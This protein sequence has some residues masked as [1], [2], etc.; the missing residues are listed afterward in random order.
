MGVTEIST[1]GSKLEYIIDALIYRI[2]EDDTND[3]QRLLE[4]ADGSLKQ[5]NDFLVGDYITFN[6]SDLKFDANNSYSLYLDTLS[7]GSKEQQ[8]FMFFA[9]KSENSKYAIALTSGETNSIKDIDDLANG[10]T[11]SV[12]I[13]NATG[14]SENLVVVERYVAS[15]ADP[16]C[17]RIT[18]TA[19]DVAD[20]AECKLVMK[21]PQGIHYKVR[22]GNIKEIPTMNSKFKLS[23]AENDAL[24]AELSR[25]SGGDFY[26][27]NDME[28]TDLISAKEIPSA[29]FFWD[30]NNWFNRFTI[31]EID[32]KN[33]DI[34]VELSSRL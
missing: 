16:L 11:N 26:Y 30:K 5:V 25:L 1:E 10:L 14:Q 9:M 15:S 28:N 20:E 2:V 3:N 12:S 6:V 17:I 24:M 7:L 33:S 13:L 27:N 8:L 31:E 21:I 18:R 34:E 4:F 22:S 29:E 23:D 32:F 19:G